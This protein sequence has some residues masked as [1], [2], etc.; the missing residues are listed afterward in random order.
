MGCGP[1]LCGPQNSVN[2][3]KNKGPSAK[4]AYPTLGSDGSGQVRFDEALGGF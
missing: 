1:F 4:E 3:K 2:L